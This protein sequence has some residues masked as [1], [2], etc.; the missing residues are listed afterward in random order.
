[1]KYLALVLICSIALLPACMDATP[2]TEGQDPGW[3]EDH[4]VAFEKARETGK[5]ILMDFTG[6]DWCGWCIKLDR[7]V[8]S[9]DEFK[10][11]A[12]EN[13]VLLEVDFP[14]RK[15]LPVEQIEANQSLAKKYG[16]RGYPTI[17]VTNADGELLGQFGYAEGGPEAWIAELE[18][19]TGLD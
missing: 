1:M 8:F 12:D 5:P 13:V 11:W 14:K 17:I 18:R 19:R 16:I 10:T 6:S 2:V 7:E 3:L 15:A 9:T 4:D